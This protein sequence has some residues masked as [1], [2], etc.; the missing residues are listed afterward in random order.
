VVAVVQRQDGRLGAVVETG[1]L[2]AV[3]RGGG[4]RLDD[5][6]I[7]IEVGGRRRRG[8]HGLRS[9]RGEARIA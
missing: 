4:R 8:L 9:N 2:T 1:E 5:M 3:H 7:A 6:I